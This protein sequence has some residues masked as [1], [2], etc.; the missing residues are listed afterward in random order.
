MKYRSAVLFGRGRLVTVKAE[1]LAALE[2]ISEHLV[3]GR[4]AEVRSPTASELNA[5]TIVAVDVE[6]A[7]AR[8]RSCPPVDGEEDYARPIWAGVLPLQEQ[9]LA[10]AADPRLAPGIEVPAHVAAYRR[11]RRPW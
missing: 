4:W 7:S 6:S 8:A 9:A 11:S 3:P 10:P 1:R 2:A 5:T